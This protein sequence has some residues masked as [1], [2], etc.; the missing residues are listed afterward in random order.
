MHTPSNSY[1][2]VSSLWASQ[3][4][5]MVPPESRA[6]ARLCEV[7]KQKNKLLNIRDLEICETE[8]IHNKEIQGIS[9]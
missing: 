3:L 5:D 8:I 9:A 1:K 7:I 6:H 4:K 2:V